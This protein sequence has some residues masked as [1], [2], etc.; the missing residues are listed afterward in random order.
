M[1]QE[2]SHIVLAMI[3]AFVFSSLF[4]ASSTSIFWLII[5]LS[6]DLHDDVTSE[7][8][9]FIKLLTLAQ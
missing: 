3:L 4:N 7:L 9:Y 6:N 2:L 8:P 5:R 1:Q